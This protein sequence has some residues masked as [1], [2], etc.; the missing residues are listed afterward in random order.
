MYCQENF[1]FRLFVPYNVDIS[2]DT[3]DYTQLNKA[4]RGLVCVML[5]L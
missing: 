2:E 1:E 3:I 5:E 4:V